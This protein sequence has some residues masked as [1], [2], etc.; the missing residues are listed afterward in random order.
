MCIFLKIFPLYYTLESL[1]LGVNLRCDRAG[2]TPASYSK[3]PESNE[4]PDIGYLKWSFPCCPSSLEPNGGMVIHIRQPG[5]LPRLFSIRYSPIMLQQVFALLS[6]F[7]VYVG[8]KGT[9]KGKAM[10]LQAWT[11][12]EG[13]RKFRLPDIKT[14]KVVRLSALRT[15]RLNSPR[16]IPG[17]HFC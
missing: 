7:A 3:G 10:T 8:S 15:G 9:G 4:G 6:C 16:S 12:P 11:G 13:S 2:S 5:S 17:T 1:V 14:M